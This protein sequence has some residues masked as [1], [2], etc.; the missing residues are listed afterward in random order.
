VEGFGHFY[1]PVRV[2][3]RA[4][5]QFPFRHVYGYRFRFAVQA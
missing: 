1:I 3:Y 2:D 5:N 4:I